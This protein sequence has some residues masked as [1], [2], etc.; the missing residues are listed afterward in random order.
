MVWAGWGVSDVVFEAPR[1]LRWSSE[2]QGSVQAENMVAPR[3][4]W[5]ESMTGVRS[6]PGP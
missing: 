4:P 3:R 5:G 6:S 1:E 2:H